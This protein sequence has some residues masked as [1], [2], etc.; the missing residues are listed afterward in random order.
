MYILVGFIILILLSIA[1][2]IMGRYRRK[3]IEGSL[4]SVYINLLELYGY[5][6]WMVSFPKYINDPEILDKV[7]KLTNIIADDVR[8]I[9]RLS[10]AQSIAE[11]LSKQEH[12]P[13]V[14]YNTC[15]TILQEMGVTVQKK[16]PN[17]AGRLRET[18][19]PKTAGEDADCLADILNPASLIDWKPSH[20]RH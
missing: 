6:F 18:I 19:L 10:I 16:Y 9:R 5:Y 3:T 2:I 7:K 11:F 14:N 17:V 20:K 8:K 12:N 1:V 13:S 15:R 4:Y